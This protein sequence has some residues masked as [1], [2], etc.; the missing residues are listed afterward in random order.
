MRPELSIA[1]VHEALAEALPEREALVFRDRRFTFAEWN[2][3]TRRFGNYL[4]GLGLGC[5]TDRARLAGWESGQDHLALYLYNGNEYLEGMVG[6]YKA[7]VAPFNV[8]Y[9]YVDDELVYL[10]ND[11]RARAIVY[12]AQFAPR[13]AEVRE[14]VPTLEHLIQ[15]DDASGNALLPGAVPYE[16]ALAASPATRC[17]DVSPDDL[18][19][20]YTGGTTGMP[21]GVLWRQSD[22]LFS[23]LGGGAHPSLESLVDAARAGGMRMLP[24]APFMHGAGHWIAL[25][26]LHGGHTCIVQDRVERLDPADIWRVCERERVDFLQIVGDAFGRP[27]LDELARGRYDLG[28]LRILLSG[29]APL[30]ASLK[31]Q[32]LERLPELSIIDG[33]GSSETGGQGAHVSNRETGAATGRFNPGPDNV[34]VDETLTR[35]LPPGHEGLGWWAKRGRVPLGY[36]G[37]REKTERTFVTIDGVRHAVPGDRARHLTD[38]TVELH[39]RDS[40]TINSGGEKIFAEEVEH[41]LKQH[42]AVYDAVVTG[43]PSERWG[44]EV[45]AVVRLVDGARVG[46]AELIEACSAHLARYKLPKAIV[47][48]DEIVRSPSGK[49]DYRWAAAQVRTESPATASKE[50]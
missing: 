32:F 3:R 23:A 5:H 31:A 33:L 34:I 16:A 43:R 20:L 10:L 2:D 21:K 17:D 15:V 6:A 22:I 35:V 25:S 44:S 18:Y 7:R 47:F 45:V 4:R 42:A 36:L 24:A 13:V 30:N 26:A 41:A 9:R 38:G 14:R 50:S 37:D 8:N 28:A 12:H 48:R 11:A 1:E 27:L 39:G 19:I 46:E 29:G 49:A 40:V